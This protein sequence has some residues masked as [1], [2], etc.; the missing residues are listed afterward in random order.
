M[1]LPELHALLD[2]VGIVLSVRGDRLHWA[3]P[4]GAMTPEVKAALAT[5]KPALLRLL[6][7][8]ESPA[9]PPPRPAELAAWPLPWRQRWG[10]LANALQ[11]A[12]TPFPESEQQAFRQIKAEMDAAPDRGES[13]ARRD[14]PEGLSDQDALAAINRAFDPVWW[15]RPP[16]GADYGDRGPRDVRRGDRWPPWRQPCASS[17]AGTAPGESSRTEEIDT[18][19]SK[20]T[21]DTKTR[22]L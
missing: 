22:N 5:H 18:A 8:V 7:G 15:S 12:G 9:P 6:S 13:I 20:L 21:Q 2:R 19:V 17:A 11:D 14:P 16:A 3:G 10:E 4:P 1:T